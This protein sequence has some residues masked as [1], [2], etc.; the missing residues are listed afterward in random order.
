MHRNLIIVFLLAPFL[1]GCLA[2]IG[3]AA[4]IMHAGWTAAKDQHE[5]REYFFADEQKREI[6]YS[7]QPPWVGDLVVTYPDAQIRYRAV[8]FMT[9]H[10]DEWI[11]LPEE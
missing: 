8:E 7:D 3:G 10:S 11:A 2:T 1:S 4:A 5:I 9:E 6:F